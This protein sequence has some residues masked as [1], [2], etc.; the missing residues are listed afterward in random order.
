MKR[1]LLLVL[2][3][4]FMSAGLMAQTK[5]GKTDTTKHTRYYTC[6]MHPNVVM[7]EPGKCPQCGMQL[8]LTDKEKIK[9]AVAKNYTCPVHADVFQHDPG[10][11]PKCGRKLN[12]SPKE[13]MKAE[14]GKVYTCP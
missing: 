3:V 10:N 8:T 12:L 5:A 1:I 11:C 13:Q 6:T 2:P 4:L 14:T 7:N 9:A